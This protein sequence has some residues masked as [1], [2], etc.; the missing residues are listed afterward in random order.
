MDEW[1]IG[2]VPSAVWMIGQTQSGVC[3]YQRVGPAGHIEDP[4]RPGFRKS[5]LLTNLGDKPLG[6]ALGTPC[7]DP[8][9]MLMSSSVRRVVGALTAF[10]LALGALVVVAPAAHAT[11]PTNVTV[12]ESSWLIGDTKAVTV[13]WTTAQT[14]TS[15][16][17]RSPWPWGAAWATGQ[18]VPVQVADTRQNV[19]HTITCTDTTSNRSVVFTLERATISGTVNCRFENSGETSPSQNLGNWKGVWIEPHTDGQSTLFIDSSSRISVAFASGLITAP[20]QPRRDTWVVGSYDRDWTPGVQAEVAIVASAPVRGFDPAT[21]T[22]PKGPVKL[23]LNAT[24]TEA[25]CTAPEYTIPPTRYIYAFFDFGRPLGE[26]ISTTAGSVTYKLSTYE[27]VLGYRLQCNITAFANNSAFTS[28][29]DVLVGKD[30]EAEGPPKPPTNIRLTGMANAILAEWDPATST[31]YP[32]MNYLGATSRN[33]VCITFVRNETVTSCVIR[34]LTPGRAYDFSV[35]ALNGMGWGEPGQAAVAARPFA[36]KVTE[37][38]RK[39]VFFG[40]GGQEVRVRGL[41]PGVPTG[42]EVQVMH[43]IGTGNWR[44]VNAT[45]TRDRGATDLDDTGRFVATIKLRGNDAR[46]TVQVMAVYT[47]KAWAA[48]PYKEDATS[49][50]KIFS[51]KPA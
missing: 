1:A 43:R 37:N 11:A 13:A 5:P 21:D 46:A 38:N 6:S 10:S 49:R 8:G 25:T 40:L 29:A 26:P 17:A 31:G 28:S 19:T 33:R 50:T 16:M 41:A 44:T 3:T 18:T 7:T 27:N 20:T 24:Q 51:I 48:S 2:M 23:E 35:R 9:G 22:A 36:I 12:S 32:V 47:V 39:R 42:A 34:D 4:P 14:V 30:P 45:V 15:A